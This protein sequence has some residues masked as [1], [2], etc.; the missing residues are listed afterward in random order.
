MSL[1]P[2]QSFPP[3]QP[4]YYAP[5]PPP[6]KSPWP[7]ILGLG[8]GIPTVLL[9]GCIAFTAQVAKK[10]AS[11]PEF[12]QE[13]KKLN[14]NTV[15][16]KITYDPATFK[17]ASTTTGFE[18][19]GSIKNKTTEELPYLQIRLAILDKNGEQIDTAIANT[20]PVA[21]NAVWKFKAP[22]VNDKA[23]TFKVIDVSNAPFDFKL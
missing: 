16:D 7:W 17:M 1:P 15:K 22:V 19:T 11:D 23:A 10:V 8:C 12:Q 2:N 9:I 5:P 18:I 4:G 21:P 3:Q 20:S 6:K 14:T 13:M